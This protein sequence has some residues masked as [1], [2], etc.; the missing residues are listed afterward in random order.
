[1]GMEG[2][3]LLL[4]G[5]L[6]C[7]AFFFSFPPTSKLLILNLSVR[8]WAHRP[9]ERSPGGLSGLIPIH[10]LYEICTH[11]TGEVTEVQNIGSHLGK[12]EFD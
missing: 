1:M 3:L 10:R 12:V 7:F 9:R 4:F 2:L 8:L 5:F 6:F 11:L